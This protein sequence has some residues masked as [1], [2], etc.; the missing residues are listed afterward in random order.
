MTHL[1]LNLA[2]IAFSLFA[3][4]TFA[5]L[6]DRSLLVSVSTAIMLSTLLVGYLPYK[7]HGYQG[8][9]V[10]VYYPA[11]LY[12]LALQHVI[13]G[14][15]AAREAVAHCL[16]ATGIVFLSVFLLEDVHLLNTGLE[17]RVDVMGARLVVFCLTQALLIYLLDRPSRLPLLLRV[18]MVLV[19][20]L[21]FD[22][23]IF[24]P[25]TFLPRYP[26]KTVAGFAAVG[27]VT[28]ITVTLLAVPIL[29]VCLHLHRKDL[30][31]RA[32]S[33]AV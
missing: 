28:K 8:Y 26:L 4:T 17:A 33:S 10:F 19:V 1:D 9:V 3:V 7:A 20:S 15:R 6:R 25:M 27:V 30:A 23:V 29:A 24:Y 31:K 2:L 12:G 22:S 32:G 11:V 5:A 14:T 18:P 13:Y 16:I 21:L